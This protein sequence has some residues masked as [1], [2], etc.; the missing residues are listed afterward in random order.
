[1]CIRSALVA[2]PG[3]LLLAADY[4]QLEIRLFAAFSGDPQL[5]REVLWGDMGRYG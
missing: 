5:Q 2:S 4:R 1:M 3:R